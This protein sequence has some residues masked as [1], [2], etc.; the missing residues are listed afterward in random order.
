MK[1]VSMLFIAAASLCLTAC[2]GQTASTTEVPT[3]TS[4]AT[5]AAQTAQA[6]STPS[7][8]PTVSSKPFATFSETLQNKDGYTGA[9]SLTFY[10]PLKNPGKALPHPANS[11]IQIPAYQNKNATKNTWIIPFSTSISNTTPNFT[12]NGHISISYNYNIDYYQI[13]ERF[14]HVTL[15]SSPFDDFSSDVYYYVGSSW[16]QPTR[17]DNSTKKI[18]GSGNI[19]CR[20]MKT[21]TK[22]TVEGY[23]VLND[24]CTPLC[25]DGLPYYL[26][27][28]F[29]ICIEYHLGAEDSYDIDLLLERALYKKDDGTFTGTFA[30]YDYAIR[31]QQDEMVKMYANMES[32]VAASPFAKKK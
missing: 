13:S 16:T 21:G 24:V 28:D 18:N 26:W 19:I 23:I 27:P 32:V 31:E 17:H 25:P 22:N 12:T 1:R 3:N 29:G 15:A 30:L 6:V 11:S 2:S 14:P 8:S 7:P 9:G 20:N 10:Q 4:Q 5:K